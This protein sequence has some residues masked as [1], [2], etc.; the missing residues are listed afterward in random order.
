MALIRTNL[1]VIVAVC[2]LCNYYSFGAIN[3]YDDCEMNAFGVAVSSVLQKTV[4]P[5]RIVRIFT[6]GDPQNLREEIDA[7]MRNAKGKLV[8]EVK[9]YERVYDGFMEK[10]EHQSGIY[11]EEDVSVNDIDMN[12]CKGFCVLLFDSLKTYIDKFD[13]VLSDSKTSD[14]FILLTFQSNLI[15]KF[16]R[17][18]SAE[19]IIQAALNHHKLSGTQ[20]SLID[21]PNI[22]TFLN[23]KN[24]IDLLTFNQFVDDDREEDPFC[25]KLH[26]KTINRFSKDKMKWESELKPIKHQINLNGCTI[27]ND[28]TREEGVN[29][30]S[31]GNESDVAQYQDQKRYSGYSIDMLNEIASFGNFK[32]HFYKDA[33]PQTE[34][35]IENLESRVSSMRTSTDRN[36]KRLSLIMMNSH[37]KAPL[38]YRQFYFVIP[39]GE[40]YSEWEKLFLAFDLVTWCFIVGT[41]VIAFVA[42]II[43]NCFASQAARNLIYGQNVTTPSLNVLIAFFGLDQQVLPTRSFARFLLMLWIIWS[44]IFR[45][46]YQGK[47]FEYLSGDGRKPQI[48]TINEMLEANFSYFIHVQ[49]CLKLVDVEFNGA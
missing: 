1:S 46:C 33:K 42:I 12:F 17:D 49:H 31:T 48:Q 13:D 34:A 30:N 7:I 29:F 14:S 40:L 8:F 45:T 16:V 28:L 41:F 4:N 22:Y 36:I 44:L 20:I 10:Q 37:I 24:S 3:I 15:I 18:A 35:E 26:K 25:R 43:I 6:F 5:F 11:D 38:V 2:V 47:L 39:R 9:Q 32:W 27:S 23:N 19:E 21:K